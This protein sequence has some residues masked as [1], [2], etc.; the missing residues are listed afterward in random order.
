V[1]DVVITL[2]GWVRAHP[3]FLL[4]TNE[5]AMRLRDATRAAD[6]AVWRRADVGHLRRG[7]QRVPPILAVE[8]AGDDED[9]Q[10]L[11]E[12]AAW[13]LGVGV[14]IVWMVLPEPREVVVITSGGEQRYGGGRVFAPDPAL[15]DLTPSVDDF[16]VQLSRL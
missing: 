4:G 3:E 14:R 13:Y 12:K 7:L 5:A 15:P 11:R 1:T 10:D 6:A 9:E 8:V 2:G 16:F